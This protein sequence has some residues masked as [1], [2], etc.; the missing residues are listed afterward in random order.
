M[1]HG[2][3]LWFGFLLRGEVTWLLRNGRI[4]FIEFKLSYIMEMPNFQKSSCPFMFS[5][6]KNS[7]TVWHIH[8]VFLPCIASTD[9]GIDFFPV[10]Y[11]S[12]LFNHHQSVLLCGSMIVCGSL[13]LVWKFFLS[14]F[15]YHDI[16]WETF[17]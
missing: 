3:E 12:I 16:K 6:K 10:L 1:F 14:V 2:K 17:V 7:F 8:K 4:V 5:L 9:F 15:C 13:I 11:V